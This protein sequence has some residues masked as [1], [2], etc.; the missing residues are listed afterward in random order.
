MRE[1]KVVL[2]L[3]KGVERVNETVVEEVGKC[4]TYWIG[5]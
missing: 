1:V 5:K 4:I 2:P 3:D